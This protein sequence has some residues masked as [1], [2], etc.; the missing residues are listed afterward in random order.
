M[1]SLSPCTYTHTHFPSS[2]RPSP[3]PAAVA[4]GKH[5]P[6]QRITEFS[7][8]SNFL[9]S[10]ITCSLWKHPLVCQLYPPSLRPGAFAEAGQ[11]PACAKPLLHTPMFSETSQCIQSLWT[12]PVHVQPDDTC[13]LQ[14]CVCSC[15]PAPVF[16]PGPGVSASIPR[17]G[18]TSR[19]SLLGWQKVPVLLGCMAAALCLLLANAFGLLFFWGGVALRSWNDNACGRAFPFVCKIPSLA[20][21]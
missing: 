1:F 13:V 19:G 8:R 14:G 5:H 18:S 11:D 21:D 10:P 17:M 15:L 3:S 12:C 2:H 9:I 16:E 6:L 20:L 4:G 7:Q